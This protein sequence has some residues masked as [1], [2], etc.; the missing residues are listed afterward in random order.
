MKSFPLK[1]S[2]HIYWV[3]VSPNRIRIN[4]FIVISHFSLRRLTWHNMLFNV[5]KGHHFHQTCQ[6]LV[7]CTLL[8]CKCP[9]GC[10]SHHN[11]D[12]LFINWLV[13]LSMHFWDHEVGHWSMHLVSN[14]NLL[15]LYV[16]I[17]HV[18][19]N[20][21]NRCCEGSS[22]NNIYRWNM[23]LIGSGDIYHKYLLRY[24]YSRTVIR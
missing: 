3:N 2:W 18:R 16:L 13:I 14:K 15:H 11:P 6:T 19:D 1:G 7:V 17:D 4:N 9:D 5:C 22:S 24:R 8:A 23:W 20:N 10:K 21:H 12:S